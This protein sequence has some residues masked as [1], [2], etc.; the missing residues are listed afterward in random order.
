MAVRRKLTLGT[1]AV[2]LQQHVMEVIGRT[3]RL[4]NALG[5]L[6][7]KVRLAIEEDMLNLGSERFVYAV[8]GGGAV[9][10]R[11]G[12]AMAASLGGYDK[13]IRELPLDDCRPIVSTQLLKDFPLRVS[14]ENIQALT[15][16]AGRLH[17]SSHVSRLAN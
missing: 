13:A 4:R 2:P 3:D 12:M 14:A 8:I 6:F 5:K 9:D 1:G 7:D 17:G 16:G 15:F 10:Q 11:D